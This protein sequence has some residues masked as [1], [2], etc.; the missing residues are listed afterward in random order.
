MK[1]Q[2]LQRLLLLAS[3]PMVCWCARLTP[4]FIPDTGSLE[5]RTLVPYRGGGWSSAYVEGAVTPYK[6]GLKMKAAM[7][8]PAP[9]FASEG[10]E[11]FVAPPPDSEPAHL[12]A[13]QESRLRASSSNPTC[14]AS[15]MDDTADS[16]RSLLA[17]DRSVNYAAGFDRVMVRRVVWPSAQR[18]DAPD[19]ALQRMSAGGEGAVIERIPWNRS[20]GEP[21]G[22]CF[23]GML[24][25]I[26]HILSRCNGIGD[27]R[28]R[29]RRSHPVPDPVIT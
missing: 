7:M 6:G 27:V 28:K 10:D 2:M 16:R 13:Y 11:L 5:S 14:S 8:L 29:Q 25:M 21:V 1:T 22:L 9:D 4:D 3:L 20:I 24:W 15:A 12:A 19:S 26:P 18:R 23:L 17:M